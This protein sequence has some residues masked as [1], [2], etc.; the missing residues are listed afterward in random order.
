MV[1][2]PVLVAAVHIAAPDLQSPSAH[3]DDGLGAL[4]I[5][6]PASGMQNQNETGE[7]ERKVRGVLCPAEQRWLTGA[8]VSAVPTVADR[9]PPPE[10]DQSMI[11]SHMYTQGWIY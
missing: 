3:P 9:Q 11:H 1:L 5:P 6:V 10:Q 2:I 4:P 7:K 8:L